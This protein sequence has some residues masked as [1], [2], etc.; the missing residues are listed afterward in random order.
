M[1]DPC[2]AGWRLPNGTIV[3]N[4]LGKTISFNATNYGAYYRSITWYQYSGYLAY[5]SGSIGSPGT[6]IVC[7]SSTITKMYQFNT[8]Y[9]GSG[10]RHSG[11]GFVGRCV[12]D[13]K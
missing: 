8:T 5:A 12:K 1:Y 11:Y 3:G 13:N 6:G 9:I 2:P 4:M 7:W 10:P